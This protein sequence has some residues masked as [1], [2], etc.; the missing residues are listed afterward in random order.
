MHL[1][2]RQHYHAFFNSELG[3]I[4]IDPAMMG[5]QID[6]HMVRTDTLSFLLHTKPVVT[7]ISLQASRGHCLTTSTQLSLHKHCMPACSACA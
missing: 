1:N 4:V 3:G 7:L 6:D 2:A 5:I